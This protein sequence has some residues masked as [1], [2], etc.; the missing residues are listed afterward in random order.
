MMVLKSFSP[1]R[2]GRDWV[3]AANLQ[4][5]SRAWLINWQHQY[6]GRNYNAE[7]GYVPRLGFIQVSPKVNY[8]FFPKAGR[9]LSHGPGI[10][11]NHITDE[12][13]K[14][15]DNTSV[16]SYN[17]TF[18]NKSTFLAWTASDYVK[19]LQPFD[20]TNFRRDTLARGTEHHWRSWGTEFVSKPQ[21]IFTYAF[22]SRYGGYFADGTRLNLTSS[23]GYRIQPFVSIAANVS[24]NDIR[25]PEP[26]GKNQFW[27]IGPRLDVTMTNTLYLTAFV[28]YNEQIKNVNLN[29]R[30]QWR[31]QPA[32]DLFIVYTDN[33]LPENFAVK[34]RALVLKFTYWW[35][36]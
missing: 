4:Y 29:A 11:T 20:P 7:V 25:L 35:N 21:S 36:L 33:Y 22:T 2:S 9:I 5:A 32:S 8:S 6:V 27:L 28:Q 26:W 14:S 17:I 31:Y 23:I 12:S 16:L 3:H 19:L 10:S 18:R 1:G 15:T 30:L 24:Y 13:V 34:S